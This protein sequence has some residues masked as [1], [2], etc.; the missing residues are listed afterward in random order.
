M[1]KMLAPP[2]KM[3][4]LEKAVEE[5]KAELARSAKYPGVVDIV[6]DSRPGKWEYQLTVKDKAKSM[7]ITAADLAE[8]VRASYYGA[9]VMR[10]QRG[11]HNLFAAA[12]SR[13]PKNRT[14]CIGIPVG[15]TEAG[16]GRHHDDIVD[17]AGRF[18]D[19]FRFGRRFDDT[20]FIAEPLHG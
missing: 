6:D 17:D 8:T 1:T 18:S 3:A 7:G 4:Q 9:E 15:C 20:Q 16:K 11:R 2:A 5:C 14:T 19:C 13:Q 10:L 12:A